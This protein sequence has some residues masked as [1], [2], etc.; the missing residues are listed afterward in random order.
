MRPFLLPKQNLTYSVWKISQKVSFNFASEASYVYILSGQKSLFEMPK[1]VNFDEFL[2]IWSLR[3]NSV[4]RQ[5]S[6]DRTKIGWKCR[7]LKIKMRYFGWFSN[8]VFLSYKDILGWC[9]S[10]KPPKNVFPKRC[11]ASANLLTNCFRDRMIIV[12]W[13]PFS[14]PIWA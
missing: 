4:T 7:N 12:L 1:M 3:S 14:K 13:S 6:F 11:N 10:P 8:I 9:S 2:K 5:M